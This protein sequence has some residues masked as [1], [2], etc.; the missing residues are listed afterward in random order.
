LGAHSGHVFPCIAAKTWGGCDVTLNGNRS[1]PLNGTRWG[2]GMM[3]GAQA[4][5]DG[6]VAFVRTDFTE[7]LKEI[8]VL[9]LVQR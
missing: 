6:I 7:D 5:C 3:D 9:V 2:Q 8:T 4:H 1:Y